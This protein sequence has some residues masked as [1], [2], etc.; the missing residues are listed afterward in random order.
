MPVLGARH[1][2]RG[3]VRHLDWRVV[4]TAPAAV[5]ACAVRVRAPHP[6]GATGQNGEAG[7]R[8]G[9]DI[10][11]TL[12]VS[13]IGKLNR[14]RHSAR[15]SVPKLSIRIGSRSA[16]ENEI[17]LRRADKSVLKA[18]FCPGC[19]ASALFPPLLDVL[20][21]NGLVGLTPLIRI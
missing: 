14:R 5:T 13:K 6:Y 16:R 3:K 15:V 2:D 9:R 1:D 10:G 7:V 4:L 18:A 17:L 19:C 8:S 11:N 21:D 20:V 12:S